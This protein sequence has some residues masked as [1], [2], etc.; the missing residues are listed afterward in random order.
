MEIEQKKLNI[1]RKLF[2]I[3]ERIGKCAFWHGLFSNVCM[4]VFHQ[5]N[6]IE[7]NHLRYDPIL[8]RNCRYTR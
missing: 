8:L 3:S 4:K 5:A 1:E 7:R 2:T 6:R